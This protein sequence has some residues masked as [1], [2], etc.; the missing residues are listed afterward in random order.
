[1]NYNY[2]NFNEFIKKI[3]LLNNKSKFVNNNFSKEIQ[4]VIDLLFLKLNNKDKKYLTILSIYIIE[5]ISFKYNFKNIELYY[6]QWRQ[7]N[8]R[9][10][11]SAILLLLPFIDD[12][13]NLL[14][15]ITDLSNILYSKK[16]DNIEDLKNIKR[17]VENIN[18]YFK[19]GNMGISLLN[20]NDDNI[21]N[22]I[23]NNKMIY[24]LLYHNFIGLLQTLQI[25]NGKSYV[26]WINI[27]PFNFDNYIS[28]P[29]YI[30]TEN[31]LKKI[32]TIV[33]TKNEFSDVIEVF[34]NCLLKYKGLWVGDFYNIIR[35]KYY[36]ELKKI[37]WLIFPY[38]TE[39]IQIYLIQGLNKMINIDF[40]INSTVNYYEYLTD[41]EKD[42]IEKKLNNVVTNFKNNITQFTNFKIDIEIIKNLLIFFINNNNACENYIDILKWKSDDENFNDTQIDDYTNN[43]SILINNITID[44]IINLLQYI[45]DNNFINYLW[46]YLKN[47][48]LQFKYSV[49]YKFLTYYDE[50]TKNF[51]LNNKYYYNVFSS[52]FNNEK[53]KN[54]L[55]L[56]NIYN[57]AKILSHNLDNWTLKES[58]FISLTVN[59]K[60]DFF[61]CLYNIENVINIKNNLKKQYINVKY[62]YNSKITEIL[63]AFKIIIIPLIFEELISSGSLNFF[64]VNLN[65][66]DKSKLPKDDNSFKI[67]R[68]NEI[69]SLIEKNEKQ[70]NKAF[71]YLTNEQYKHTTNFFTDLKKD[72]RWLLFYAMDWISQISFFHHY[73][74]HQVLYITGA[75]GQGKS[76]QVP[77]LLLYALKVIDYKSNGKIICT[78]PRIIPANDNSKTITEQLGFPFFNEKNII[79]NNYYVQY[80]H[81][82]NNHYT[83]FDKHHLSLKIVT[84]GI[85]YEKIKE[86]IIMKKKHNNTYINENIYDILIID[87]AHEHNPNMDLIL[88]LARQ[89]CSFN[90]QIRLVIVSATMDSDEL[91]YRQYYKNINDK[92]L[93]PIK[94]SFNEPILKNDKY[95]FNPIFMDRRYHISPPGETT[96]YIIDENYED[97][98][99]EQDEI[100]NLSIK[101]VENICNNTNKGDIL[102]FTNG[103]SE[104]FNIV[105]KLNKKLPDNVIALPLYAQLH[106]NY[107]SI[108]KNA[109]YKQIKIK[110]ENVHIKWKDTYFEDKE[111]SFEYNR[112]VIVATNIAEASI[113]FQSIVYVID[114]GYSKVKK[115]DPLLDKDTLSIE[116]ITES[117][118]LQRKGRVGRVGYGKIFYLYPLNSRKNIISKYKITQENFAPHYIN[119]YHNYNGYNI[120]NNKKNNI[121]VVYEYNPNSVRFNKNNDNNNDNKINDLYF[122]KSKLYDIFKINY[123]INENTDEYYYYL[124]NLQNNN[125]L[126]FNY[127][128]DSENYHTLLNTGQINSNLQDNKGEF[129]LIHYFESHIIRNIYNEIIYFDNKKIKNNI[130]AIPYLHYKFLHNY[131]F[132]NN[133]VID[134]NFQNF[135]KLNAPIFVKTEVGEKYYTYSKKFPLEL[136]PNDIY[137]LIHANKL[138]CLFSVYYLIILINNMD[139]NSVAGIINTD[140]GFMQSYKQFKQLYNNYKSEILLLYNIIEQIYY[141][142]NDLLVFKTNNNYI[143]IHLKEEINELINNFLKNDNKKYKNDLINLL[144]KK[145]YNNELTIDNLLKDPIIFKTTQIYKKITTNLENNETEI[146]KWCN[147]NMIN[148][149]VIKKLLLT[150]IDDK[151][152]NRFEN[153]NFSNNYENILKSFVFGNP[154]NISF[155]NHENKTLVPYYYIN[156]YYNID[157]TIKITNFSLVNISEYLIFYLFFDVNDDIIEISFINEIKTEYLS[158]IMPNFYYSTNL[159]KKYKILKHVYYDIVNNYNYKSI[160]FD[161][162]YPILNEHYKYLISNIKKIE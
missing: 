162:D 24:E 85:L 78:V 1:M 139:K 137:T 72:S 54:K 73:I 118:R 9:D 84:D 55:N 154:T 131:L 44:D 49:L 5:L 34:G 16:P 156:D 151:F 15:N 96:Q 91:I 6:N 27:E 22:S 128:N 97:K 53:I 69:S 47:V 74:F 89:T 10:V 100:I 98:E 135:R 13:E 94:K 132:N 20:K 103:E 83:E 41:N 56:K 31:V 35:I 160:W 28:S 112:I 65:I 126:Y 36:Q 80:K 64:S 88:S 81:Q 60:C 68:S 109:Q 75:T 116:K 104:I 30:A 95:L 46:N 82:E 141:K 124:H 121:L 3:D 77:K 79:N 37:K 61:A 43:I 45:I 17:N 134:Y 108:I 101:K 52:K 32:E 158:L 129:F 87:E 152:T 42:N 59:K 150:M 86:N 115:Y 39:D 21:K 117:S 145:K 33:K 62:D 133:L 114:N 122:I 63:E 155:Y 8:Y 153:I 99:Y 102:V 58:N 71:Y 148:Y 130:S 38:E 7:N 147:N 136:K 93:Y 120:I 23:Y 90:N 123:N 26:N 110:K 107:T 146:I 125:N 127:L 4:N 161:N 67:F 142:F 105:E 144:I 70:W 111:K 51:K 29:F 140:S 11:K 143:N 76:T 25:I 14:E 18:E 138:N 40:I 66:T 2:I 50:N 113:T 12:K 57:I 149:K 159:L 106:S 119:L 19:F 92:L 157:K 48:I